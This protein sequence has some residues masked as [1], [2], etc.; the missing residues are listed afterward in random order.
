MRKKYKR[1]PL[2]DKASLF[3]LA[4]FGLFFSMPY[5]LIHLIDM[6][7]VTDFIAGV[8]GAL[9]SAAGIRNAVSGSLLNAPP[10][11]Y[12]IVPDCSGFVLISAFAA[13]AFASRTTLRKQMVSIALFSPVLFVFNIFR[14][15]ATLLVGVRAPAYLDAAHFSFWLIDGALVMLLWLAAVKHVVKP[16]NAAELI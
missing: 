3:F 10:Q 4:K 11:A 15:F 16:K 5:V 13:L 14:L 9:L 12:E 8:E 1:M 2:L 6:R 7:A